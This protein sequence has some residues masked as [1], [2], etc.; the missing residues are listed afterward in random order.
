[1]KTSVRE[2]TTSPRYIDMVH[3]EIVYDNNKVIFET[4]ILTYDKN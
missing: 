4:T 1:M 2:N 3:E